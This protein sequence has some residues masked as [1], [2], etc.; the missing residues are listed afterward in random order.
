MVRDMI[1]ADPAAR[2]R[3]KAR[4]DRKYSLELIF[5]EGFQ[6]RR[7]GAQ[8]VVFGDA[9]EDM[10]TA[11]MEQGRLRDRALGRTGTDTAP[12]ERSIGDLLNRFEAVALGAFV[13]VKRHRE[14]GVPRRALLHNVS[15]I[16]ANPTVPLSRLGYN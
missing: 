1:A 12:S 5:L 4:E 2:V 13:F 9:V 3:D 10:N 8:R 6:R 15:P 16:F 7:A 14:D 11:V